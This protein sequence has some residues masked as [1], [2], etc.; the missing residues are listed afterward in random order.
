MATSKREF[1]IE[2]MAKTDKPTPINLTNHT[3]FNLSGMRDE[4]ILNHELWINSDA[5]TELG[6]NFIPTGQIKEL[7][8]Y[9]DFR[10]QKKIGYDIEKT[11]GGYDHNYV[12]K[13]TP[14]HEPKARLYEPKSGRVMEVFTNQPGLQFYTGNF[15]DGSI[16]GKKGIRYK[17]HAGLCL[18]TQHFPDSP[19]HPQFPNT[20]LYPGELFQSKTVYRFTTKRT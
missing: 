1:I 2:Y 15:L 12:L 13:K 10:I 3:Y 5:F 4:T 9:L 7:N 14:F 11:L 18:E 17:R 8:K 6:A 19:H 20:I 16:K